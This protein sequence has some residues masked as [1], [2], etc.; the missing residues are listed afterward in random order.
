MIL[1]NF[2]G[3]IVLCSL[4]L[5][6]PAYAATTDFSVR[7]FV[8]SDTT[9]PTT[10]TLV[11][12]VPVAT[13]QINVTWTASTDDVALSGYRLFRNGTQIATTTLLSYSDT[14]LTASTTY[15]YFVDAFDFFGNI[16]SSSLTLATTTLVN[17]PPIATTTPAT[18]G[19]SGTA[20]GTNLRALTVTPGERSAVFTWQTQGQTQYTLRFGR[21]SSYELGAVSGTLYSQNHSTTIDGL[22]PGTTYYY[23]LIAIDARGTQNVVARDSF[24]TLVNNSTTVLAN[25][26]GFSASVDD[27]DVRLQWRNSFE[28]AETYV[29]IV[30]SHLFYP[31]TIQSGAVVYE[32][33]G[34]SFTDT[35]AL[36][37]RSPQ[38]YTIFVLDKNRNVSSG[39]VAIARA[40][41]PAGTVETVPTT[42]P[43]T[44][45]PEIGDDTILRAGDIS[46]EQGTATIPFDARVQLNKDD[47]FTVSVPYTAVPK[48]L[49]S[50]IV[51]I[52]NPTNQ[53]EIS[54]YLLKLNQSGDAYVTI[55]PA[56]K[57]VGE[58]RITLEVFD[59]EQA[60]IRRISNTVVFID[61][62]K[63][64]PFLSET[65]LLY[66]WLLVATLVFTTIVGWMWWLLGGARRSKKSA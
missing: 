48:N 3:I 10:P 64:S 51:S 2:Y 31:S 65:R 18:G 7:T 42:T 39:A 53:R 44:Q 45:L 60:T 8:G 24:T 4:V 62:T 5:A 37:M 55:V 6:Q 54:A 56:I 27:V 22:E 52:Q 11:S 36:L 14:S 29:R 12:V 20:I 40:Q 30:R 32:G 66:V 61:T 46:F 19:T 26:T 35:D 25:V 21:T 34:E 33:S 1:K 57:V 41:V 13:T 16:S 49:K 47:T 59:Y 58:A 38:Y 50:I 63:P 15:S 17:P 28:S 43:P 9:A 23:E